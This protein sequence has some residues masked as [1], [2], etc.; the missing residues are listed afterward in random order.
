MKIRFEV[1]N[2]GILK[3][4]LKRILE[5][6]IGCIAFT[7][8]KDYDEYH[9]NNTTY[10]VDVELKDLVILGEH[11]K[12]TVWKDAILIGLWRK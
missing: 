3:G 2:I 4:D 6:Y 12:V 11:F 9:I 7:Q 8:R 1:G 10:E 5:Y